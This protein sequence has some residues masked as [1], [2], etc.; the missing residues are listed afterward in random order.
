MSL[1]DLTPAQAAEIQ[2][3]FNDGWGDLIAWAT[4]YRTLCQ[5]ERRRGPMMG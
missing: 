4:V 3:P 1:D 2:L 5:M